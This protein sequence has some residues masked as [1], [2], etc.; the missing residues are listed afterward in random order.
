MSEP[1]HPSVYTEH[2]NHAKFTASSPTDSGLSRRQFLGFGAAGLAGAALLTSPLFSHPAFALAANNAAAVTGRV[3]KTGLQLYTVRDLMADNVTKTLQ[4]VAKVGFEELEFAGYFDH[5]PKDLRAILDGE[6]LTAPSCHLP[7]E[8]FDNGT[9]AIIDAALTMGHQYVVIPYLT[10]QQRGTGIDTYQ[11]LAAR[12]NQIGEALHK[13]GLKFAYHNHDFEFQRTD[14]QL[15]YDVLLA[16]TDPR[17]VSMEL[18]LFWTIKAKQDPLAYFANH[19]GRF[20]L[21]HVKDMDSAGN[22]ADV[23]KGNIDF[24]TIFAKADVAGLA[25]AFIEHDATKDPVATISQ[26]FTTLKSLRS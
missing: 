25:H 15:P 14:N 12:F 13:A 21:W 2:R 1:K 18:D 6:G 3:G 10:E 16:Q 24:K 26:G 8:A 19:P 4:L 11:K 7:I 9:D 23:G 22:F 17:Y 5:K 20:P